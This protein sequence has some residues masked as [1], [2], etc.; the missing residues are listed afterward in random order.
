MVGGGRVVP[1]PPFHPFP[2]REEDRFKSLSG[3]V[4]P[5]LRPTVLMRARLGGHSWQF[6]ALIDSGAPHTLFDRGT[7]DALHI[8]YSRGDAERESFKVAGEDRIAQM[9]T[10]QLKIPYGDFAPFE[11]EARVGFFLTD[12][13]MPFAGLLGQDGFLDRWVVSFDYPHSFVIE[14]RE[15][16]LTRIPSVGLNEEEIAKIWESQELGWRAPPGTR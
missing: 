12:W 15:S 7:G 8:D 13:N 1:E 9:E 10:V 11:W 16:F 2:Y 14:A 4:Y 5:I 3:E 6:R